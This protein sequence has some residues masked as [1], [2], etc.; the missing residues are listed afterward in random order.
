L[1]NLQVPDA[2]SQAVMKALANDIADRF[3]TITAFKAAL[4]GE[5]YIE[6]VTSQKP[7][8]LKYSIRPFIF[9][10]LIILAVLPTRS[11]FSHVS[12]KEEI[13]LLLQQ[14][15]QQW[16]AKQIYQPDDNNVYV[17]YQKI[18]QLVDNHPKA[19]KGLEKVMDY[20]KKTALEQQ[21]L[22]KRL[23]F[24][25]QGLQL[26]PDD[27]DLLAFEK[28]TQIDIEQM[29]QQQM[30]MQKI[31][32]LLTQAQQHFSANE[33]KTTAQRYQEILSFDP[34]HEMAQQGLQQVAQRYKKIAQ[35]KNSLFIVNQGLDLFPRHAG[36]LSLQQKLTQSIKK[37]NQI[38]KL[39]KQ[40]QQQLKS[41][42]LTEPKG[43]NAYETYQLLQQLAPQHPAIQTGFTHMANAYEKLAIK[44]KNEEKQLAYINKGLNIV[45]H[46]QGL[47]T[48]KRQLSQVETSIAPP[49]KIIVEKKIPVQ[50]KI[51][52]PSQPVEKVDSNVNTQ[53][54]VIQNLVRIAQQYLDNKQL[55]PAYQTYQNMLLIDAN[56]KVAQ[57]GLAKIL[58]SYIQYANSKKAQ[59]LW[60]D[61]LAIIE[62]GLRFYPKNIKL[63]QLQ[64]KVKQH[65]EN[66]EKL[67]EK[68]DE[69]SD[70]NIIFTP[71]F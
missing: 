17:T 57:A 27:T 40:A 2:I 35:E 11:H 33:L 5:I 68:V 51:P 67:P 37:Q 36:L 71:S 62:E 49:Q 69:D 21:D 12:Q 61:S 70:N 9:I 1:P 19:K 64:T 13:A 30:K 10:F 42:Q 55:E 31:Q 7:S 32:T 38:D 60:K 58:E 3:Q 63:L 43:N 59:N 20:F 52:M 47:L 50:Q 24:I 18:L 22:M 48:L 44:T 45:P 65:I 6:P 66:K 4:Q 25:Q 8:S 56:N 46:H 41:V 34:K 28:R 54:N 15:T 29:Q 14:A 39:L 26:F 16:Q 53:K 23:T